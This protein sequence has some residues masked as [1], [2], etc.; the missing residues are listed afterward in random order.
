MQRVCCGQCGGGTHLVG[1][2]CVQD[3]EGETNAGDGEVTLVH[4][5]DGPLVLGAECV[6]QKLCYYRCLAH[7][8]WAHNDDFVAGVGRSNGVIHRVV[9]A[10][11]TYE[12]C[13]FRKEAW[14]GKRK[15]WLEWVKFGAIQLNSEPLLSILMYDLIT[16]KP[17][18]RPAGP[19]SLPL[20]FCSHFQSES[21]DRGFIPR[22]TH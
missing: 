16:G 11:S 5:L 12:W 1:A 4:L 6:V 20:P 7:L 21:W 17:A 14:N 15:T 3:V 2:G 22:A 13:D 9:S 18:C 8:G 10:H 19:C